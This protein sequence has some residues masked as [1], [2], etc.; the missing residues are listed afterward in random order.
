M[1]RIGKYCSA[2][3]TSSI[4]VAE[5]NTSLCPPHTDHLSSS[6]PIMERNEA[7][8]LHDLERYDKLQHYLLQ[9]KEVTRLHGVTYQKTVFTHTYVRLKDFSAVTMKN[10]SAPMFRTLSMVFQQSAEFTL[11]SV[12]QTVVRGPQV[13]LG[14]CPCGPLRLNISSKKTE[15]IKLT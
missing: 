3:L 8:M 15:K 4:P 14:F 13:V 5:G 12:S 7:E 2:V 6:D 1:G 11:S 9:V 10:L